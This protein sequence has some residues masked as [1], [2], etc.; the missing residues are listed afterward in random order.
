LWEGMEAGGMG[1]SWD[2]VVPLGDGLPDAEDGVDGGVDGDV[3][4]RAA[5]TVESV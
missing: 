4:G 1:W 3:G 5:E 2:R